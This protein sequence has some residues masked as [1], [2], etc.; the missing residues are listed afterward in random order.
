MTFKAGDKLK[1]VDFFAVSGEKLRKYMLD[2]KNKTFTFERYVNFTNLLRVKE[3]P[4]EDFDCGRFVLAAAPQA[5]DYFVM[6]MYSERIVKTHLSSEDDAKI[7]ITNNGIK[8]QEYAIMKAY[9]VSKV[10][11]RV[12]NTEITFLENSK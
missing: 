8:D 4:W 11:K 9:L 1:V 7:W 3:I 5:Y 10:T 6:M 12:K 2:N